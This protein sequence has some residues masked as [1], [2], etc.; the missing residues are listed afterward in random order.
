MNVLLKSLL[1]DAVA[2]YGNQD[3]STVRTAAARKRGR[4]T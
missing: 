1:I 3:R 4:S 2:V